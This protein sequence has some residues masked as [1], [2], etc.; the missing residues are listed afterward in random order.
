MESIIRWWK[1]YR[2]RKQGRELV[3]HAWKLLRMNHDILDE[4]DARNLAALCCDA[5]QAVIENRP[6]LIVETAEK[7]ERKLE[8]VF[9]RGKGSTWRE[10]VEVLLVA[11]I[12][13]MGVRTFFVQPFK[14]PTGSMQPTLYGIYPPE[15]D[16]PSAY[17][18]HTPSLPDKLFGIVFQGRIYQRIGYRTRGDHIFVDKISYHFRKPDRGEIIVFE[19]SDIADLPASSR[20]KFYIKR[21]VGLPGDKIQIKPP[22]VFVNGRGLNNRD[23]FR[24]IYS[25]QNG[26]NG[27]RIP[28]TFPPP[29]YIRSSEDEYEVPRDGYFVLGDNSASSLDGRFWGAFPQK[30]L[31]GRAVFVYWPFS[32]RF[33]CVD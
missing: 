10:N 24:R 31:V 29:K 27:Y 30:A 21:L 14:I 13:A 2:R 15:P 12:V 25:L 4:R 28:S 9:P 17:G 3:K 32:K 33:G 26:Y 18:D 5:E 22:E 23:A 11:V 19:T 1:G 16:L 7:L 20:G 8:A 6:H